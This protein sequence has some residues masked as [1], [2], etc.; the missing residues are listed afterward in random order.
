MCK[1]IGKERI[2][3]QKGFFYYV[4][5]DGYVWGIPTKRNT[6]GTKMKV[7][8]TNVDYRPGHVYYLDSAGFVCEAELDKKTPAAQDNC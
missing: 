4:S 3:R 1:R 6:A 2:C 8:R 7:S 5:Y